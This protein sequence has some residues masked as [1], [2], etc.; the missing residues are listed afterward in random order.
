MNVDFLHNQIIRDTISDKF[1][2]SFNE[3]LLPSLLSEYGSALKELQFYEDHLASG[4]RVNGEFFYPL[5]VVTD[6]APFTRWI[7][8]KV[9]NYRNYE[10][11]NP[12]T[13]K[14]KKLLDFELLSTAP[15]KFE[16]KLVGKSI[17]APEG[18]M[19]L[20]LSVPTPDK[21]FLAGKYSQS[22]VDE[23][24]RVITARIEEELEISGLSESGVVLELA[25]LPGTFM[26]HVVE[27]TTY[28]R[29]LIK[30]RGCNARDLWIKW[31]RLDGEGTYTFTDDVACDEIEFDLGEDVPGKIR[32]KEYRYLS[33]ESVNKFQAAMSRKNITEWR[34]VM[35]RVV[36]RGEVE[37]FGEPV[38]EA[39]I[40]EPEIEPV[41]EA[42]EPEIEV[43]VVEIA[44][45]AVAPE[46]VEPVT[47]PCEE[48]AAEEEESVEEVT[49]EATEEATEE[50]ETVSMIDPELVAMLT[51]KLDKVE[52]AEEAN[53]IDSDLADLLKSA[54]GIVAEVAEK[55]GEE[56]YVSENAPVEEAAPEVVEEPVEEA[57]AEAVEAEAAEVEEAEAEQAA[58][59][60]PEVEAVEEAAEAEEE[61]TEAAD[62]VV[63]AAALEA[64]IRA[65]LE[66]KIRAEL[67][68]EMKL[69]ADEA[70]LIRERF[71]AQMRQEQREKELMA[72]AALAAIEAQ[73][74]LAKQREEE[75]RQ[76]EIEEARRKEE[77][78]IRKEEEARA[79][80]EARIKAEREAE[81]ARLK[82]EEEERRKAEEEARIKAVEEAKA[83]AEK[84]LMG[85]SVYVSKTVRLYFRNNIDNNITKRIHEI[86]L[87]TIKY[88]H[89]EDVYIR[90][91]ANVPDS[92]TVVL[93][94]V[95]IPEEELPLL[96][97]IIKVLGRSDLSITKA[98]VD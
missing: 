23:L 54:I 80:E 93:N 11:F 69:K 25:F 65:E 86:I 21:T 18:S 43:E 84:A 62:E 29:I 48:C 74:K 72:E 56:A 49:E 50:E 92:N 57:T 67:E 53:E 39:K 82:A 10:N 96:V 76:R 32:E 46:A 88:F 59:E 15:A 2:E 87:A 38:E 20:I 28:R 55:G 60:A 40:T 85:D 91:K 19:P 6:G 51:E 5:T 33:S 89:K 37:S 79:A 16:E 36:R 61:S 97:N 22:F 73:Q 34:D 4:F 45:A 35:R 42:V 26:E 44:E 78:A 52:E 9:A 90:I 12:Y 8:W 31:T 70:A 75:A 83:E 13:Y 94:F 58:E 66:A 41:L 14:G 30:A 95:K 47:E 63:D 81:E 1:I 98:T 71:E 24:S 27:N 3:N 17:Y 77:E 68:V 7:K 64:K